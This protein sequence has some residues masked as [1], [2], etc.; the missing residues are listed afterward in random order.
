MAIPQRRPVSVTHARVATGVA[1]E[2]HLKP[3]RALTR[4]AAAKTPFEY[5]N[6]HSVVALDAAES[7]GTGGSLPTGLL[8]M[9]GYSFQ[10]T[11][12]DYDMRKLL[13]ALI[14]SAFA[15]VSFAQDKM[16]DEKKKAE[17]TKPYANTPAENKAPAAPAKDAAPV[18]KDAA[19]A[20]AKDA[21]AKKDAAPAAKK[22]NKMAKDEKP[23]T[24]ADKTKEDMKKDVKKP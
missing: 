11:F 18:K 3:S 5:V 20:A 17:A 2:R 10:P 22:T 12:Q 4:F 8:V 24:A 14:A 19:P 13:V 15:T 1:K 6:P 23:N 9:L 7:I 16:K 21:P